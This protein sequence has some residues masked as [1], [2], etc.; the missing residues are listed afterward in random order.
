MVASASLI[1]MLDFKSD[2]ECLEEA[3]GD[4]VHWIE[5]I[6]TDKWKQN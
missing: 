1:F 3:G 2:Y 4:V 5:N 6:T